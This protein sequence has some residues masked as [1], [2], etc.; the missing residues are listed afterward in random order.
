MNGY[1][2]F[3]KQKRVEVE[4]ETMLA[5]RDKAVKLFKAKR[6]YDVVCV[7]AEKDNKPVIHDGAELP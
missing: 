6:P 3:Y 1:V 2:C 4:A 5:A 7:L